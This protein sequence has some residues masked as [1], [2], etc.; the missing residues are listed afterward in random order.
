MGLSIDSYDIVKNNVTHF[1]NAYKWAFPAEYQATIKQ[2]QENRNKNIKA[3]GDITKTNKTDY[4]ERVIHEMPET[5]FNIL[6]KRLTQEELDWLGS[7]KG[8]RW[9]ATNFPEF[10][11]VEKV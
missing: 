3:S 7:V 8:A 5:L 4:L 10:S 1:V 9:F 6:N 2:V 11:R